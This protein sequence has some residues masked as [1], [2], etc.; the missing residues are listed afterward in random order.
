MSTDGTPVTDPLV[1][2]TDEELALL[3]A[4]HPIVVQP[5]LE[6]LDQAQRSLAVSVA[7]RALVA[8]G[9][10]LTQDGALELPA[11]IIDL[12]RLRQSGRRALVL[13]AGFADG[14][15]SAC[16]LHDLQGSWLV[17]DVGAEGMHDFRW[18]DGPDVHDYVG[19][20]LEALAVVPGSGARL[21]LDA[22]EEP[23]G[24]F[25]VRIDATLWRSG[26]EAG[27]LIGAIGGSRG[28]WLTDVTPG[29]PDEPWL[30]PTGVDGLCARVLSLLDPGDGNEVVGGWDGTMSL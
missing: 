24:D 25:R 28:T 7:G 21:R 26:Q 2:L 6:P 9:V 3:G 23:W 14:V 20:W 8:H 30:V 22:G 15:E 17:E 18:V 13:V 5:F 19:R 16:Y 1:C 11:Q 29:G 27:R 10:R 4:T 12:L